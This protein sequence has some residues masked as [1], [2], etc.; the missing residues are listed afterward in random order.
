MSNTSDNV[1]SKHEINAL[2]PDDS[3]TNSNSQ[4]RELHQL[5]QMQDNAK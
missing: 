1:I 5:L 3:V 2:I 4:E